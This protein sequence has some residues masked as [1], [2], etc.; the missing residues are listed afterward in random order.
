VFFY[1]WLSY[2]NAKTN[3]IYA[4]APPQKAK[5]VI[6]GTGCGKTFII[7][8][9]AKLLQCEVIRIDSATLVQTG[10]V[11][12][13]LSTDI[14]SGMID[15]GC[16]ISENKKFLIFIDEFDKLAQQNGD[17]K[18]K[19]VLYE[20]L[21]ILESKNIKGQNSYEK[22]AGQ[23]EISIENVLFVF[24]GAFEGLIDP[25]KN[26]VGYKVENSNCETKITTEDI[27]QYGIPREVMGRI[28]A[29]IQLNKTSKET[30]KNI[31]LHSV[32]GIKYYKS[33]FERENID[34]DFENCQQLFSTLVDDAYN[35]NLGGRAL[36]SSLADYFEN[37]IIN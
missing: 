21:T 16:L 22:N 12:S 29:P 24:A 18:G 23:S 5:I 35:Q 7:N 15:K 33:F 8:E 1:Q 14:I 17:I 32:Q 27:I 37:L 20:L 36:F 28:S 9:I 30:L 2:W 34:F 6:G 3:N 4:I 26:P 25:T 11:G 10:Y 31:L 13:N 19:T